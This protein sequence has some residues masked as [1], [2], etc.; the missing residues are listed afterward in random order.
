MKEFLK[1]SF[2]YL[3][4][5]KIALVI[6]LASLVWTN[7]SLKYWKT[8][9]QTINWD[10]ILYYEYLPAAIIHQ[11]LSMSF[12]KD[13]PK[14]YG[15]KIWAFTS[16]TGKSVNKMTMGV[17]VLYSPFFLV[18]H[19]LAGL[20]GYPAD[21]YSVPYR[22]VLIFSSVFY[23][24]L[25]LWLLLK[26]LRKYFAR[27]AIAVSLLAIGIGT[28]LYYY[29]T[30]TAPVSH[31]YSFF[32][33][34]AFMYAVDLWVQKASWKNSILI[35]IVGGLIT[36][37]RPTNCIIFLLLPLWKVDSLVAL[38][39]RLKL[40]LYRPLNLIL[41]IIIACLV[42]SPQLIYWKYV[43][44][45][46]FYYSYGEERFFF[47]NPVFLKGL[48][49][50]RKGWLVYTPVMTFALIGFIVLYFRN[51]KF[52]WPVIIFTMLNMY[53]IWSWWCWWYGGGFGQRALIESY[54][55]LA[56]PLTAFTEY[57]FDKK[58]MI[59]A[60]FL[61]LI[62]CFIG[63]NIFQSWQCSMGMIHYDA[64][65]KKAYWDSYFRTKI[66][67]GFYEKLD[68]PDIKTAM[69]GDR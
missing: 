11:D 31:S 47:N 18:A 10:I 37:V 29:T 3:G 20:L 2:L 15:D 64:M 65:T 56:I 53:I 41:I 16:P 43:T 57:I 21:G 19:G 8:L 35:G 60:S 14:F 32:L 39:S 26:L 50:Y 68:Y 46:Y 48:F 67:P 12:T 6:I 58:L 63:L 45:S 4:W 27:N 28:N 17:A 42:F 22:F 54:A 62:V 23:A 25:G 40:L 44:G 55:L 59:R 38:K 13:D 61:L 7:L 5:D 1:K 30:Y 9:K 33:F 24:M 34:A 69:N 66:G 49:S 51:R 52:F 36:L